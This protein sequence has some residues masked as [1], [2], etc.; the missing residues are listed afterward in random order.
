MEHYLERLPE[1]A[2]IRYSDG[3]IMPYDYTSATHA[4][5]NYLCADCSLGQQTVSPVQV[6]SIYIVS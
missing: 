3:E 4:P 5:S 6:R 1:E 2:A